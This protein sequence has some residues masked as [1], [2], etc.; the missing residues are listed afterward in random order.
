MELVNLL[1]LFYYKIFCLI[2]A[3]HKKYTKEIIIKNKSLTIMTV[4]SNQKNKK[5]KKDKETKNNLIDE[6]N[7]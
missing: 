4:S 3:I 2:V 5:I 6:K 7:W 1:Q